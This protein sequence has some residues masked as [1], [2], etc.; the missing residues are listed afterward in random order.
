MPLLTILIVL[1]VAGL[2]LWL[3]NNYIPMDQKIKNILNVVIVVVV[4]VWLLKV[5]GIFAY[6]SKARI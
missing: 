1:I 3:A 5:F 2:L 4:I 6:L